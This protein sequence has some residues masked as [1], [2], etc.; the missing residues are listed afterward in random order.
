MNI[1]PL[2]SQYS[3]LDSNTVL[4]PNKTSDLILE[5]EM[6]DSFKFTLKLEFK[7]DKNSKTTIKAASDTDTN[8]I[9]FTCFNFNDV[10]GEGILS[11]IDLATHKGK[12]IYFSFWTAVLGSESA[13]RVLYSFYTE[14]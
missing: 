7:A 10:Q 12:K 14:R 5:I 8:T 3:I 2:T 1:T 4:L 11:P 13:R 9:T 6:D